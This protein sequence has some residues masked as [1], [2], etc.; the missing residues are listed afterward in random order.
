MKKKKF[1]FNNIRSMKDKKIHDPQQIIILK[2]KAAGRSR[3]KTN[4]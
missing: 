3:K 1:N 4:I 2:A